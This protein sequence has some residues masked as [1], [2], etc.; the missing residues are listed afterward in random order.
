[1]KR[2]T[3]IN[4]KLNH[5]NDVISLQQKRKQPSCKKVQPY[6]KEK[7]SKAEV[8]RVSRR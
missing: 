2:L 8:K 4:H 3:A 1:M 5:K 7:Y 6:E